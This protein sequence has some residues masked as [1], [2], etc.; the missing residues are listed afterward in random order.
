MPSVLSSLK[1]SGKALKTLWQSFKKIQ[2]KGPV[3]KHRAK[4]LKHWAKQLKLCPGQSS[5]NT[6][7]KAVKTLG[8]AVKT[9]GFK[10]LK[11]LGVLST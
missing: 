3:L 10:Q 9:L 1:H 7:G 2:G 8:K 4:Q 11:H 6:L 5:Q